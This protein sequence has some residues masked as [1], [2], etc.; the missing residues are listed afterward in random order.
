LRTR[1]KAGGW[2]RAKVVAWA[3][4]SVIGIGGTVWLL[5]AGQPLAA[6]GLG[7]GLL[8]LAGVLWGRQWG[9]AVFAAIAL[10]WIGP[11]AALALVATGVFWLLD[12]VVRRFDSPFPL[13]PPELLPEPAPSS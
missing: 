6:I 10:P 2:K 11:A 12:R 13:P 8:L 1:W 7:L 3:L 5:A 9:A 4:S